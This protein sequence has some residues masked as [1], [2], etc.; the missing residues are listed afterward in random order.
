MLIVL[1][2]ALVKSSCLKCWTIFRVCIDKIQDS[3]W[4]YSKNKVKCIKA[5]ANP[6]K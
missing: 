4:I 3:F 1:F 5:I 2:N 6:G